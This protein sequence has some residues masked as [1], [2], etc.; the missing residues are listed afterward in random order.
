MLIPLGSV[1]TEGTESYNIII[2]LA[3]NGIP[4]AF[5]ALAEQF[6]LLAPF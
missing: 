3:I 4:F 2:G 1:Y 5:V 6:V